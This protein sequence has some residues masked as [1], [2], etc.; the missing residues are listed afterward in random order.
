MAYH[1]HKVNETIFT[2]FLNGDKESLTLNTLQNFFNETI[3]NFSEKWILILD[4]QYDSQEFSTLVGERLYGHKYCILMDY[5]TKIS[6]SIG[7]PNP[8]DTNSIENRQKSIIIYEPCPFCFK[9]M[10]SVFQEYLKNDKGSYIGS[11][12]KYILI[13]TFSLAFKTKKG[14]YFSTTKTQSGSTENIEVFLNVDDVFVSYNIDEESIE[15]DKLLV[16]KKFKRLLKIQEV[17]RKDI[18]LKNYPIQKL[19]SLIDLSLDIFDLMKGINEYIRGDALLYLDWGTWETPCF[20]QFNSTLLK[21]FRDETITEDTL[22]LVRKRISQKIEEIDELG[23]QFKELANN[24]NKFSY[25]ILRRK[26]QSGNGFKNFEFLSKEFLYKL[27]LKTKDIF[28]KT[29]SQTG[30]FGKKC[31]QKC[32][33]LVKKPW[34]H[35]PLAYVIL[36]ILSALFQALFNIKLPDFFNGT[37]P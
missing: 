19:I 33:Y 10:Y 25:S 3:E 24:Q 22:K 12:I 2:G 5:K 8:K 37:D 11:D 34:F 36:S 18:L 26:K 35:I 16:F 15:N 7:I 17:N 21:D 20:Q 9:E 4:D 29:I 32:V 23:S 30:Q 28:S 13:R 6:Y 1:A 27:Q 14:D 31:V